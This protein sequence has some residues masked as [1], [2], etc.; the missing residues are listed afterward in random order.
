MSIQLLIN[1][2]LDG[3]ALDF[4]GIQVGN[5]GRR[6]D[7]S[8]VSARLGDEVAVECLLALELVLLSLKVFFLVSVR[9]FRDLG[10]EVHLSA[11]A[12]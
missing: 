7:V 11:M 2:V 9:S 3:A 10:I 1:R 5:P 12:A 8:R 6:A 4:D